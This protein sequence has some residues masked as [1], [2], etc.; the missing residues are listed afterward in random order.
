MTWTDVYALTK[1][2]DLPSMAEPVMVMTTCQKCG[3]RIVTEAS[4]S[5]HCSICGM[6]FMPTMTMA[7]LEEN[8]TQGKWR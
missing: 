2:K 4:R 5:A 1:L 8:T 7:D 6:M 3:T